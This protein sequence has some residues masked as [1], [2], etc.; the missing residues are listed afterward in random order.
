MGLFSYYARWILRFSDKIRDLS[1]ANRYPL[2]AVAVQSFETLR[3]DL[4]IAC[5]QC[6]RDDEPFVVE[7]DASD[8]AIAAV[9]SQGGRPVAFMSR[10]LSKSECRHPSVEKEATSIIEAVRK[11]AHYLHGRTF[12]LVTDQKS[13]AFMFY[14]K[15]KGKIKNAKNLS[16]RIELDTFSYN[17]I[18][19]PGSENVAAD[20]LSRVIAVSNSHL[21]LRKIHENLGHP[22]ITRLHHFIRSKNLPYS[23]EEVRSFCSKCNVCAERKPRFFKKG[24]ETLI[25]A[26]QP[27]S[28][29]IIKGL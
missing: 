7:C 1:L 27:A 14:Q 28:A 17:V 15:R 24:K 2:P 26:M 9:L 18:H 22:G 3:Q 19:R 13:L 12:T 20:A 6:I 29:Y 16:W 8:F 23:L 21:G 4:A 25:K 11:W 10:T 5:L